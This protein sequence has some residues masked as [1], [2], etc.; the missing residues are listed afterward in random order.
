MAKAFV[1]EGARWTDPPVEV[2][3]RAAWW[4]ISGAMSKAFTDEEARDSGVAGRPAVVARRGEERP[5]TPEGHRLLLGELERLSTD[6][7]RAL[8][9]ITDAAARETARARLEHRIALTAATLSSVRVLEPPPA[10]GEVRFGSHVT[11]EWEDGRVQRLRLVGPDESDSTAGLV[12]VEAPLAR[13]LLGHR[14][15]DEVE[16]ERPGGARSATLLEVS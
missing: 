5:I 13:A 3:L 12:S 2:R 6:E 4:T 7:R 8:A 11:L 10:D 15:G 9:D 1:D 16:V 14:R